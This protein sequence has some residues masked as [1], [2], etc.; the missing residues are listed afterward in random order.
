MQKNALSIKNPVSYLVCSGV[1]WVE[2]RTW[3]TEYRGRVYIHSSTMKN[4]GFAGREFF[5]KK[6][7]ED[8]DKVLKEI[9]YAEPSKEYAEDFVKK[10]GEA[11]WLDVALMADGLSN[12]YEYYDVSYGTSWDECKDKKSQEAFFKG[13]EKRLKGFAIIGHVDLVDVKKDSQSAWA[14]KGCYHWLFDNPVLYKKPVINVKGKL[15]LFDVSHIAMPD[16]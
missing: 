8:Y 11:R 5:P 9:G 16:D 4:Y 7:I 10:N 15:R 6:L 13:R 14:E 2:N 1:K 12:L 3:N